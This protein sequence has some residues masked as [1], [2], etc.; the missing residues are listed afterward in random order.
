MADFLKVK[1][2]HQWGSEDAPPGGDFDIIMDREKEL[3]NRAKKRKLEGTMGKIRADGT[4]GVGSKKTT[5]DDEGA[6]VGDELKLIDSSAVDHST[7]TEEQDAN[8]ERVKEMMAS[9]KDDDKKNEKQRLREKR[10]KAKGEKE[11]ES[12][13]ESGEDSG[14]GSGS[15]E[16]DSDS[17]SSGD[18]DDVEAMEAKAL[19]MLK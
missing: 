13:S 17:S 11:E 5:F 6:E 12:E 18:E 16:S 4:V 1:Q 3:S 15:D 7:L 19:A 10:L 2:S 14:E 9:M 8:V